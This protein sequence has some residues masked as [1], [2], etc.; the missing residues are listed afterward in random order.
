M[1]EVEIWDQRP[2]P[3]LCPY[4]YLCLSLCLSICLSA[5]LPASI[6]VDWKAER[7]VMYRWSPPLLKS[8]W[9]VSRSET[10]PSHFLCP[11]PISVCLSVCPSTPIHKTHSE[12][13][14]TNKYWYLQAEGNG[15]NQSVKPEVGRASSAS[16]WS[17]LD[18]TS[19]ENSILFALITQFY[20]R[21]EP[22]F[23]CD[24]NSHLLLHNH[25][26]ATF[27][28]T[29]VSHYFCSQFHRNSMTNAIHSMPRYFMLEPAN[30]LPHLNWSI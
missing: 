2:H 7:L 3:S 30:E 20:L 13:I 6:A 12:H 1:T 26:F 19:A 15:T 14:S 28:S 23:I 17:E 5:C 24:F 22:D 27:G 11:V 18:F 10:S 25:T 16:N 21:W 9:R 4:L 8:T 29:I